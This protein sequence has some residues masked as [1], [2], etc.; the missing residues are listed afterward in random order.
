MSIILF[1]DGPL[2]LIIEY[3]AQGSLK[4]FLTLCKQNTEKLSKSSPS[5]VGKSTGY[6]N[7]SK[8]IQSV[9][10]PVRHYINTDSNWYMY[11]KQVTERSSTDNYSTKVSHLP[12]KDY[13]D[14]PGKLGVVD[15][16]YFL[17]QIAKGMEHIGKM[18]VSGWP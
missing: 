9:T 16:Y 5:A 2:C 13:S 1:V 6:Y 14:T 4:H 15:I 17:L 3:A 12:Q 7:E 11:E 8:I 18:K 10:Q